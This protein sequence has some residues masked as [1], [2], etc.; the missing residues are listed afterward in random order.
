MI[1]RDFLEIKYKIKELAQMI[2]KSMNN[3]KRDSFE[4]KK[5]Y[6]LLEVLQEDLDSATCDM[7]YYI[8]TATESKLRKRSD[9]RYETS[10]E[11][12]CY[13]SG[14]RIEAL[15]YDEYEGK[16]VWHQGIVEYKHSKGEYYFQNNDVD[17]VPLHNGMYVR[18]RS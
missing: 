4:N 12:V 15:V 3:Y 10:D 8:K 6:S 7:A 18:Y 17:D 1:D 11:A 14:T 16:E 13:T 5:I 9:G 2:D